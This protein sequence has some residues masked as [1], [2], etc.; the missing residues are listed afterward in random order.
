MS[1][2]VRESITLNE[3]F[4]EDMSDPINDMSIGGYSY[5]TLRPGAV[6]R[7]KMNISISRND[8]GRLTYWGK[9]I[10]IAQGSPIIVVSS[11]NYVI[12]GSKE[13]KLYK[14][15]GSSDADVEAAR[16]GIKLDP[17]WDKWGTKTRLI[18]S[19]VQFNNKFEVTERGF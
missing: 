11:R 12:K 19:K 10:N 8:N 18:I 6:L 15:S 5:D 14:P 17:N 9:G 16:Q 2:L 3:K 7:P 13:I 1:K 4:S